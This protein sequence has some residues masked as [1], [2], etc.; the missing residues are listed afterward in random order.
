M[1]AG[2]ICKAGNS[3][4]V[5]IPPKEMKARGLRE[6]QLVGFDPV[7]REVR[8]AAPPRLAPEAEADLRGGAAG[9]QSLYPRA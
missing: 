8:S 9:A 1:I 7:P 2:R 4:V 6:G 5:A 3:D